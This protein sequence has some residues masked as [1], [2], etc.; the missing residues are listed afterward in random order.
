MT[1]SFELVPHI[2]KYD[3]YLFKTHS[4]EVN[5]VRSSGR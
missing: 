1:E 4:M 3:V 2:N 5:Y